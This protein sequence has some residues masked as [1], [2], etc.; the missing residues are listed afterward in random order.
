MKSFG[1]CFLKCGRMQKFS[2]MVP[3]K[4]KPMNPD[5]KFSISYHIAENEKEE[6]VN[7]SSEK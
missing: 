3:T 5:Y 4:N 7:R 2:Q 1:F 6:K